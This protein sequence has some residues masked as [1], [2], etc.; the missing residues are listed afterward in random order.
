[1]SVIWT[2][3]TKSGLGDRLID[4]LIMSSF[5][6]Y[7]GKKLKLNYKIQPFYSSPQELLRPKYRHFDYKLEYLN[8]YID[9]PN[10]VYLYED[11]IQ[12]TK[13]R[14]TIYFRYYLGGIYSP[15]TFYDKY[16][17]RNNIDKEFFIKLFLEQAKT[18]N[19]KNIEEKYIDL[20]KCEYI[21][22]HLRRT[23]KVSNLCGNDHHGIFVEELDSLNS[24]TKNVIDFFIDKKNIK[25]IYFC[26]DDNC[27]INEYIQNYKHKINI[28]NNFININD[29]IY[30]VYFDLYALSRS[31]FIILS[32]KHSSFSLF[33]SFIHNAY[34]I[35]L[36]DNDIINQTYYNNFNNIVYYKNIQLLNL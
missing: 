26:G 4:L 25:N 3:S 6:K 34:L 10:N 23:D 18:I 30:N 33:C 36:Y 17:N 28:L 2:E 27:I 31:K 13:E 24:I 29:N 22:I 5:A 15:F 35:Y 11:N 1:M 19:F 8:K 21:S 9:L 12:I 7:L 20:F 16:I 14:N 32:Q